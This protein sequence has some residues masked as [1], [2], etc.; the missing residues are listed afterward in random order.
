MIGEMTQQLVKQLVEQV[1][2][3]ARGKGFLSYDEINALL[4]PGMTEVAVIEALLSVLERRGIRVGEECDRP[5]PVNAPPS[6]AMP[7]EPAPASP[8]AFFED[9]LRPYLQ[10]M[11]RIA[12]LSAEEESALMA[13]ICRTESRF[14]KL[15][16]RLPATAVF[17]IK[18]AEAAEQGTAVQWF[19]LAG[20]ATGQGMDETAGTPLLRA[21]ASDLRTAHGGVALDAVVA[22]IRQALEVVQDEWSLLS[23]VATLPG[24]AAWQRRHLARARIA[25]ARSVLALPLSRAGLAALLEALESGHRTG[26]AWLLTAAE[27]AEVTRL[28]KQARQRFDQAARARQRLVETNL[29]LVVS[30]AKH[31]THRGL[32]LT[33]LIQEGNL[34]L[35]Q[36]AERFGGQRQERFASYATWW[37]RR[38]IAQA[39]SEQPRLIRLPAAVRA[40]LTRLLE[41]MHQLALERHREPKQAELAEYLGISLEHVQM[42]LQLAQPPVSLETP[43]GDE[44]DLSLGDFIADVHAPSPLDDAA[45]I[46]LR[47]NLN[48]ALQSLNAREEKVLRMRFGLGADGKAHTLEEIAQFFALSRERIQRIEAEALEKLRRPARSQRLRHFLDDV[49]PERSA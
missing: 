19:E 31:Y 45:R 46:R 44:E 20:T 41:A 26:A 13:G 34:G 24:S 11:G 49:A 39:L 9:P 25:L 28:L 30:V 42:L 18:Q 3:A 5:L 29:R 6:G 27:P 48:A 33:D 15:L 1:T 35:L 32:G 14:R 7:E 10:E 21:A 47:E 38:A 4:P 22:S 12:T 23:A 36:A 37:I 8:T 40:E 43:V 17:L 16:A 2:T